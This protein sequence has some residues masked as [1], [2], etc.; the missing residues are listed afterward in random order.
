M[1]IL[2]CR[3]FAG[4][5]RATP[6][7]ISFVAA[8]LFFRWFLFLE[9]LPRFPSSSFTSFTCHSPLLDK[10]FSAFNGMFSCWRPAF[11]RSFSRHGNYGRG[12]CYGGRD[13]R[14]RLQL[15]RFHGRVCFCSS[16]FSSN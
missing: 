8:A 14:P 11:C 9:S 7:S 10:C 16:S 1:L 2:F 6:F 15:L 4:S 12:S 5:T 3:H 13:Q